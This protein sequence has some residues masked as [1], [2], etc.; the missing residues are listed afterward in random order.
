MV[1]KSFAQATL[2]T[3]DNTIASTSLSNDIVLGPGEYTTIEELPLSGNKVGDQALVTSTN[4][5]YIWTGSGW[6]TI[7]LINQTPTWDSNGQPLSTYS[8]DADSPQQSIVITLLA[9]DPEGFPISYSAIADSDFLS[10][11][12]ISQDSSIFTITPKTESQVPEGGSGYVTFKATDGSNIASSIAEFTLI[13]LKNFG[14]IVQPNNATTQAISSYSTNDSR[15]FTIVTT[16]DHI[17]IEGNNG[18]STSNQI[19]RAPLNSSGDI[20]GAFTTPTFNWFASNR[21]FRGAAFY[22]NG[23]KAWICRPLAS[24]GTAVW[25]DFSLSTPY[26]LTTATS[27]S[28]SS[29]IVSTSAPSGNGCAVFR[30]NGNL[31]FSQKSSGIEKYILTTPYDLTTAT[32]SQQISGGQSYSQHFMSE[33]GNT[34]IATSDNTYTIEQYNL[35]QPFDLSGI[36]LSQTYSTSDVYYRATGITGSMSPWGMNLYHNLT[37]K[38][39]SSNWDSPYRVYTW[40]IPGPYKVQAVQPSASLSHSSGTVRA[41][42]I[43]SEGTRLYTTE[44]STGTTRQWNLSTPYDLTT[45]S[46]INV[47]TSIRSN[48]WNIQFKND[49]TLLFMSDNSGNLVSYSLSNPWDITSVGSNP[50]AS[51][52]M[53]SSTANKYGT[54]C[55]TPTGSG[56]IIASYDSGIIYQYSLST[57]WDITNITQVAS[58]SGIGYT[59][60]SPRFNATGE[61]IFI[62]SISP[63]RIYEYDLAS[64]YDITSQTYTG[65][66]F[67]LRS[68]DTSGSTFSCEYDPSGD[69]FFVWGYSTGLVYSVDNS[70]WPNYQ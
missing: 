70:S 20:T 33:D 9:T 23:S 49:G 43:T 15:T 56:L 38:V 25:E 51:I 54:F 65:N 16:P 24:G 17:Y 5:L 11:A 59:P 41:G 29:T 39:Y 6:Y 45:A 30:D 66:V 63:I 52:T 10:I 62:N 1:S 21:R 47:K 53:P 8:L 64:P 60:V 57:P 69:Q 32:L 26:D 31:F 3:A 2:L 68:I 40:T 13:F 61:K 48:I 46:Y 4:K 28:I 18:F 14:I 50:I 19:Y 12:S 37:N 35:S 34:L 7:A 22:N 27:L 67:D 58:W 36:T 55:F 44:Y 42:T